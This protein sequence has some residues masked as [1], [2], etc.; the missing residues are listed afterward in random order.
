MRTLRIIRSSTVSAAVLVSLALLFTGASVW[1]VSPGEKGLIIFTANPTG[2]SQIYTINPDGSNMVQITNLP[3]TKQEGLQP[4]FSP[5]GR[6]I[7]FSYGAGS[8]GPDLYVVNSDGSRLTQLTFDGLSSAGR[9][10]PDG[11]RIVFAQTSTL[12]GVNVIISMRADGKGKKAAL[13]SRF[14]DS[15]EPAYTPDG[16]QIV[17]YSQQGGLL[18]AVWI[19]NADGTDKNRLT[20][21]ALEL[22]PYDVAP[23]G[24]RILMWNHNS[25]S[26]PTSIFVMN[27]DGTDI[28]QLTHSRGHHDLDPSYSPDGTMIV[29]ASDR[30]SS[31]ASLDLFTMNADGSDIK[32]IATGLTV[33]G[34]P[35]QNCVTPSWGPKTTN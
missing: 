31:N 11:S 12:T 25:T 21:A 33:G 24:Q 1:A 9:W 23:N 6:R 13:T 5:D 26:L 4:T 20:P 8:A 16:K 19:M 3:P 29:F 10:S 7:L 28:R 22:F 15:Y 27:I 2:S 17:Y 18:E 35:D 14:W 30:L 32:R 34:C